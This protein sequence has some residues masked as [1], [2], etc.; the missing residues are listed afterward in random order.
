MGASISDA[1]GAFDRLPAGGVGDLLA[2]LMAQW[3][4]ERLGKPF[5]IGPRRHASCV[6]IVEKLNQ[7]INAGIADPKI[8]AR[9]ADFGGT[10]LS[11][12]AAVQDSRKWPNAAS[13]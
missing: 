9:I 1:A 2:R 6:E 4:S 10:V 5:V 11:G 3:L 12:S 7:E 13:G 8:E